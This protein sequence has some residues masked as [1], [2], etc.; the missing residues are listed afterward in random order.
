M[1]HLLNF[2]TVAE[3][4]A[5]KDSLEHPY[6]VTIDE[7]NGL[8]YNTDVIR[9]PEGQ[10]GA[11]EGGSSWKYYDCSNAQDSKFMLGTLF[12]LVKCLNNSD[13]SVI[14][15]TFLLTA[16]KTIVA[17]AVDLSAPIKDANSDSII[18]MEEYYAQQGIAEA[19]STIGI[20]EISKEQFYTL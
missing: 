12:H 7:N 4:D 6:V 3:Y 1:K 15:T 17:C 19:F 5:V 20:V 14:S 18:T 9:V 10:G 16:A 13:Q 8:K 2:D 11:S